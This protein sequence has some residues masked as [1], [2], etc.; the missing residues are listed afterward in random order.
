MTYNDSWKKFIATSKHFDK[1]Q[2]FV[3]NE[4]DICP[5]KDK[6]FRFMSCDLDNAKCIILGM[7]PYPSTYKE[8]NQVLPVATGRSFEVAN[9]KLFIDRYKQ[10][11][12]A[13]IFKALNYYKYDKVYT[14][15]E[16]RKMHMDTDDEL[17][18]MH[19][20][21]DRMEEQGV[22]FLNATLTTKVGKSG[23]HINLW[24]DFMDEVI[25]YMAQ[26]KLKW[27]IWGDSA[28][29]RVENIVDKNDIIYSCHPA[30]RVNNNFI[31]DCCFKKVK[32]IKWF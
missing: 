15:D 22:I 2:R 18:D 6:V 9:V 7:D 23:A 17:I 31:T 11:S 12:L 13:N 28:L 10:T 8:E 5:E 24:K 1:M 26:R 32:N 21:F 14:M 30:S 4:K 29:K 25:S 3:D 16:L 20:W 19:R 27:L